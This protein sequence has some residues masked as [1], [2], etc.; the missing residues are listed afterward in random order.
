MF[1]MQGNSYSWTADDSI[2][3]NGNKYLFAKPTSAI[4]NFPSSELI[5]STKPYS[6]LVNIDPSHLISGNN[7]IKIYLNDVRILNPH[8]ELTFPL[9]SEPTYTPPKNIHANY[10]QTLMNF[11]N[12][13]V[14]GPGLVFNKVDGYELYQSEFSKVNDPISG[15]VLRY[16]KSTP[17]VDNFD[18]DI[19][20]DCF[21][22]L[23]A[24]GHAHGIKEYSIYL[25]NNK[26]STV[27][28]N[29]DTTPT[30]FHHKNV[31][32]DVTSLVR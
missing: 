10:N 18:V 12:T 22:Q 21:S 9:A 8:I 19:I 27:L 3:I 5:T 32:V 13:A 26:V 7:I 1:T 15:Q 23:A 31:N 6:A 20:G 29:N 11:K 16:V 28:F 17:V 30:F 14:V 24:S 25:D 4:Q 2:I